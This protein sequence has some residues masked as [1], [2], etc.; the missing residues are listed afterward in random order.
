M[1]RSGMHVFFLMVFLV[2]LTACPSGP[3]GSPGGAV[4]LAMDAMVHRDAEMLI[5]ASC[6][7]RTDCADLKETDALMNSIIDRLSLDTSGKISIGRTFKKDKGRKASV[8]FILTQHGE[9]QQYVMNAQRQD[10]EW[11]AIP[12]SISKND[13]QL[14]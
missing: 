3:N 11:V 14:W 2:F 13:R 4:V 6:G 10:K 5:K 12:E 9:K 7:N 1:R 8:Y